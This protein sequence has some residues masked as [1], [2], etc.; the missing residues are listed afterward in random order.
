LVPGRETNQPTSVAYRLGIDIGGTFTDLVLLGA[1]GSVHIA[2]IVSTPP[3]FGVGVIR[4]L[5]RVVA[6]AG[7]SPTAILGVIHGTTVAA[8]A[9]LE[10]RGAKTALVTTRGFRD[11]L[12]LGRMR[13]PVLYNIQWDKP[14]PL[15][16]RRLRLELDFRIDSS[17]NLERPL[18]PSALDDV[19]RKLRRHEVES[20]AICFIN[21][22]LNPELEKAVAKDLRSRYPEVYVSASADISPEIREFERTST[23]VVNAYVQPLV[24]NYIDDL[25]KQFAAERV[26]GSLQIMQSSGG[27]VDAAGARAK[28]VRLIESGPA[29]GVTAT[30]FLAKQLGTPNLIAFDMG[31]TTAKG[32]LI[33]A[34]EPFEATEYEVGGGMNTRRGLARGNGYT[35]R[36]PSIDIAEVGAGGGS[37]CWIDSGGSPRVGPQSSGAVPGPA[38]YG[39]GG[40][41]PTLTDAQVVL[42]YLNPQGLAGGVQPIDRSRAVYVMREL[43]ANPLG[44]DLLEA[45]YGVCQIGVVN[46]SKAVKAVSS[47]R[48]RDP[49]DFVLVAFG[50][51]GPAYA[52]EM[53]RELGMNRVVVPINA[54]LFSTIGLLV[55]D[56]QQHDAR[57][58]TKKDQLDVEEIAGTFADL[59]RGLL[60]DLEQQGYAT[61]DI[62]LDRLA[63]LHYVGQSSEL[64]VNVPGGDL[65]SSDITSLRER[66]DLEHERT[67]GHRGTGQRVEL[68]NLR[69]R[70]T[71]RSPERD[72]FDVFRLAPQPSGVDIQDQGP[73]AS[74]EAY[75]GPTHGLVNTLVIDRSRLSAEPMPGPIIIEDV[76]ATTV[77]P[78]GARV[79]RDSFG[80]IHIEVEQDA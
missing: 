33:E 40:D 53:A 42:G 36:V 80:N 24:A 55:A 57:T 46:M 75:F 4:G 56:I 23:T 10:G 37:I 41:L 17:G 6:D 73:T 65:S 3:D 14:K 31:G 9:I 28:P 22:Y 34:G 1:N 29:A 11:V 59:E 79:R 68:A 48:G 78:P 72:R 54:G 76:D 58:Y 27:V 61:N 77:I 60:L 8:N 66:F 39:A 26:P 7:I 43:F 74:R 71:V 30:R 51:A 47:E 45:A 49:R 32:S 20:V 21:S 18:D 44:L 15:V 70:A 12:E 64:R 2:K 67:Y 52:V 19:V 25:E 63:D 35:V 50:G 13:Y 16:P 38:C 5:H 69:V 62:V